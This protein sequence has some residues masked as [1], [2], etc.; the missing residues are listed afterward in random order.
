MNKYEG[1]RQDLRE[2]G[3]YGHFAAVES[4]CDR[5]L[6]RGKCSASGAKNYV[7]VPSQ[8]RRARAVVSKALLAKYLPMIKFEEAKK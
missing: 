5:C 4:K 3:S 7:I 2:L 8:C 1:L 6:I